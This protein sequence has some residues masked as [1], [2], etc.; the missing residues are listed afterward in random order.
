MSKLTKKLLMIFCLI[1]LVLVVNSL[2]PIT[3]GNPVIAGNSFDEDQLREM[4]Y[5]YTEE[6]LNEFYESDHFKTLKSIDLET[7]EKPEEIS[8]NKAIEDIE[9]LFEILKYS[10]AGYQLFGGDENFLEARGKIISEL[11]T[12]FKNQDDITREELINMI[13]QELGFINDNHFFLEDRQLGQTSILFTSD[14]YKFTRNSEGDFQTK[15]EEILIVEDEIKVNQPETDTLQL[16][17]TISDGETVYYPGV[18]RGFS[19]QELEEIQQEVNIQEKEFTREWEFTNKAENTNE[20]AELTLS[21]NDAY[22]GGYLEPADD[23]YNLTERNGVKVIELRSLAPREDEDEKQLQKF[24]EDAKELQDEDKIII[25]IR[26]NS[27]GSSEYVEGWMKNFTGE[28]ISRDLITLHLS[29]KSSRK[30]FKDNMVKMYGQQRA[31]EIIDMLAGFEIEPRGWPEPQYVSQDKISNDTEIIVLID[32][33]VM[34]AGEGFVNNFRN[35]ENVEIYGTNTIGGYTVGNVGSTLLPNSKISLIF[36]VSLFLDADLVIREGIGRL[37][38]Y[39][40]D[41]HE[42]NELFLD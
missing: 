18:L 35:M 42:I 5:V 10:Y 33:M 3:E 4:V 21:V 27:G 17:P 11:E 28:E 34:S 36:G 37:P 14:R 22:G 16:W 26:A 15:D 13:Y 40:L 8:Y 24:A 6:E 31:E 7:T 39:W 38:D 2:I 30:V 29:T 19:P 32:Q 25:D 9:Y 41:Q 23:I 20:S 12:S 1:L